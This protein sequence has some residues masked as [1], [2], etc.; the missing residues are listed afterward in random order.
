[1]NPKLYFPPCSWYIEIGFKTIG[2]NTACCN[3]NLCS[4]QGS[5][6]NEVTDLNQGSKRAAID[7]NA[8]G[9]GWEIIGKFRILT[10]MW[11]LLELYMYGQRCSCQLWFRWYHSGLWVRKLWVKFNSR[12]FSS[13]IYT[14]APVQRWG[15]T[16]HCQRRCALDVIL[17]A[18]LFS[19]LVNIEDPKGRHE[20]GIGVSYSQPV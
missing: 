7:L 11:A 17:N 18:A 19:F 5:W 9:V 10:A 3:T 20:W 14:D 2:K 15:C 12:D 8:L 13:R 16:L 4:R 6:F 1:M